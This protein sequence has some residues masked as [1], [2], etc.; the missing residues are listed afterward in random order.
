V[1]EKPIDPRMYQKIGN[2]LKKIN[3]KKMQH[4]DPATPVLEIL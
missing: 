4:K 1:S 3:F 2:L